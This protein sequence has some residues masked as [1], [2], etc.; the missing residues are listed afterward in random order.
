LEPRQEWHFRALVLDA[1][2]VRATVASIR[3]EE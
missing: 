1:K 3:E 2:T